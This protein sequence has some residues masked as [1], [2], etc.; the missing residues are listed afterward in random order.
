MPRKLYARPAFQSRDQEAVFEIVRRHPFGVLVTVDEQGSP[1][2]THV[3]MTLHA[4]GSILRGHVARGNPH[5]ALLDRPTLAVFNGPHAYI[6]PTAYAEPDVPTWDYVAA[7]LRGPMRRITVEHDRDALSGIIRD[8][9][10]AT[11]PGGPHTFDELDGD[12]IEALLRG[13]VG[14]EM[15]VQ[16]A[17]G[18]EK[19]SQNR[20]AGDRQAVGEQLCEAGRAVLDAMHRRQ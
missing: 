12:Y 17:E 10:E 13:I 14:F 16:S 2:A 4:G 8:L 11:N 5:Q 20:P 3:P 9:L 1:R 7:H 6:D 19:L 18:I 15:T